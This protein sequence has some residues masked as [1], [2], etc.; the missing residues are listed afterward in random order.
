M[1]LLFYS[2]PFFTWQ[3]VGKKKKKQ[4]MKMFFPGVFIILIVIWVDSF[5]RGLRSLSLSSRH[6]QA[7]MH[8]Y[9]GFGKV[10]GL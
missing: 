1:S 4:N 2:C 9:I 7:N 10:V 8:H 3:S 5:S 6:V